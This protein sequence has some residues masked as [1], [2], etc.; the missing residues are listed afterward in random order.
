MKKKPKEKHPELLDEAVISIP[1][2]DELLKELYEE[3]RRDDAILERT[4]Q[5]YLE[6]CKCKK[7]KA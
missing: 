1:D 5:R 3:R 7:E 6:D 4:L 2:S